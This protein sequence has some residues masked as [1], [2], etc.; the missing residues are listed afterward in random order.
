[1]VRIHPAVRQQM[2]DETQKLREQLEAQKSLNASLVA[3]AQSTKKRKSANLNEELVSL[4]KSTVRDHVFKKFKFVTNDE[5]NLALCNAT[6]TAMNKEELTGEGPEKDLARTKFQVDY[7]DTI[8]SSLNNSRNYVQTQTQRSAYEWWESHNKTLPSFKDIA[9]CFQRKLDTTDAENADSILFYC[10]YFLPKLTGNARD[11]S[12]KIRYFQTISEA[13]SGSNA[14]HFDITPETEAF[15]L[16]LFENYRE[17]WLEIFKIKEKIKKKAKAKK[18]RIAV[19]SK[20]KSAAHTESG[21]CE[22]YYTEDNEK[23]ATKYTDPS[24]G[25]KQFGGWTNDGIK[26]YSSYRIY[27][28]KVRKKDYCAAWETAVK[29]LLRKERSI[30]EATWE[31]EQKKKGK[32]AKASPTA[33]VPVVA[34]LFAD[35]PSDEGS[36]GSIEITEL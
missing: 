19:V 16:V 11:Y 27:Q 22:Y 21:K 17:K 20:K 25:Q 5:Q 30:T 32:A 29:D 12:D 9:D 35:V 23:L 6:I 26:K 13:K 18:H 36:L 34:D 4:I 3:S 2:A 8:S 15:G 33:A 14:E 31:L 28:I 7:G 1:M 10:E 24:S